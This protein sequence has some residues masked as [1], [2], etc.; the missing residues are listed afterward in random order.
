MKQNYLSHVIV[1]ACLVL[2]SA[3][4]ASNLGFPIGIW[5]DGRV[6]GINVPEGCVNVPRDM[7]KAEAYYTRA[8]TDMRAHSIGVVVIPNTPPD[9]RE[10]LLSC[11][12]RAGIKVVL[13]ITELASPEFGKDLSVRSDAFPKDDKVLLERL[14]P[15]IEPLETHSS[16]W[17]YQIADEP[18]AELA[19][20][21][22]RATSALKKLDPNRFAFSCL[23]SEGELARTAAMGLPALVFDRYIIGAGAP[24]G[25]VDVS[26]WAYLCDTLDQHA[27]A[28]D[29]P[30]WMVV[31]T[32]AIPRSL[33]MPTPGELRLMTYLALGRNAKGIFY[34]LYN[35]NT[36][37]EHLEGVVDPAFTPHPLFDAIAELSKALEQIGPVLLDLKPAP[38]IASGNGAEVRTFVDG[39]KR[40]YLFVTNLDAA[41]S[42]TFAGLLG[43][44]AP[45]R[46]HAL[47]DVATGET[48]TLGREDGFATFQVALAPGQ[49]RLLKVE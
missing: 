47:A 27:R 37:L 9:Y 34:F 18:P 33:R 22:R 13:E 26:G 29:I 45:E 44:R 41:N 14:R 2:S 8:F 25:R 24:E 30:Y 35:S 19:G 49:G 48:F 36:Q 1:L 6:E 28:Y 15:I 7:A 38:A 23:C 17:A 46:F 3:A 31:Q 5:M 21:V 39:K 16:L 11:A 4:G 20:R 12:D 43:G 40:P 42:K 10:T 32:C